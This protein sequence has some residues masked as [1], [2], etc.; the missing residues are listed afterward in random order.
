MPVRI[1]VDLAPEQPTAIPPPQN[2][3]AVNGAFLAAIRDANPALA[4]ALHDAPR[5]KPF[6]LTPLLDGRDRT[7]TEPGIPARFEV[8]LLADELTA[9]VLAALHT[10]ARHRVGS[11]TYRTEDVTVLSAQDYPTIARAATQV[12]RWSFTLL[13]PVS[14]AT[15]AD[16]GARR[17]H[18][19]PTPERVFANLADRWDTFAGPAHLPDSVRHTIEDHLET[20]GGAVR[21]T[22]HLVKTPN[23]HRTGAVGTVTYAVAD[24]KSVPPKA[25]FALNA[26]ATFATTAGFGDRTALGMGYVRLTGQ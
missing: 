4:S 5:Y 8:G 22:R 15:A 1:R 12:V 21:L 2:A 23:I 24:P 6:T 10:R 13:T 9:P 17:E 19:W 18:P 11:T 14:F 16:Q 25:V 20:V 26:L 3:P 7:P